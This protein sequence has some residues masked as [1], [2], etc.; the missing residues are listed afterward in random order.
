MV[1]KQELENA[2][3][4]LKND[5]KKAENHTILKIDRKLKAFKRTLKQMPGHEKTKRK[6]LKFAEEKNALKNIY[7][8][9]EKRRKIV[10]ISTQDLIKVMASPKSTLEE[11]AIA[12]LLYQNDF[13][14]QSIEK[15]KESLKLKEDDAEWLEILMRSG[16][17]VQ[18]QQSI[19]EVENETD[20]EEE[21][22]LSSPE[23]SNHISNSF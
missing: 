8:N 19:S 4:S 22:Y 10:K 3:A 6:M 14:K 23:K 12:K 20:D 1:D 9:P 15:M 13:L 11:K 2:V 5:V 21:K 17:K 7:K 18:K 16:K